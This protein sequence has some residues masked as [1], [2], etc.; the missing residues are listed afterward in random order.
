MVYSCIVTY[1]GPTQIR[2]SRLRHEY[3][4]LLA[5]VKKKSHTATRQIENAYTILFLLHIDACASNRLPAIKH[6][7]LPAQASRWCELDRWWRWLLHLVWRTR[8]HQEGPRRAC[9][10]KFRR[11]TR[12]ILSKTGGSWS[13]MAPSD[14]YDLR[15]LHVDCGRDR[16]S[17]NPCLHLAECIQLTQISFVQLVAS[18]Y[19]CENFLCLCVIF[20]WQLTVNYLLLAKWLVTGVLKQL[21]SG[22]LPWFGELHITGGLFL[23]ISR[24]HSSQ[25]G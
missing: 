13:G 1:R 21:I 12:N 15:E 9:V 3:M 16:L 22:T 17:T 5:W 23:R 6:D 14:A 24:S 18:R 19:P 11:I 2:C 20:F 10:G 25:W 8:S 7:W 4:T